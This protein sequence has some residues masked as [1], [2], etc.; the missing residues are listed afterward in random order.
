MY[1]VSCSLKMYEDADDIE[2]YNFKVLVVGEVAV[3]QYAFMYY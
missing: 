3:G 2:E 1:Q